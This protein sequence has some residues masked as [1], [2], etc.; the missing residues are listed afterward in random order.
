MTELIRFDDLPDIL[1]PKHLFAYLP[2]GRD[3]VYHALQTQAIRNVRI[4]QKFLIPKA[5]LQEFLDVANELDT[6]ARTVQEETD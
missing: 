3:A 6:P 4:G 2:I 5:A 1:T